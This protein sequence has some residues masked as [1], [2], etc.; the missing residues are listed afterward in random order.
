MTQ[1]V[2]PGD[3]AFWENEATL[4]WEHALDELQAQAELALGHA[5][6]GMAAVKA[7]AKVPGLPATTAG[8]PLTD[9]LAPWRLDDGLGPLPAGLAG[10]AREVA[11]LQEQA[12]GLLR[13]ASSGVEHEIQAITRPRTPAR[14][15]Y[16]DVA[17]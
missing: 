14:S 8:G 12:V 17:G 13:E 1:G 5:R 10:R 2:W 6:D 11:A 15:L 7:A 9:L 3:T 16:L 4:P